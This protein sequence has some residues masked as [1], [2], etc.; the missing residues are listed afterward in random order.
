MTKK[1]LNEHF[2]N[3]ID[4]LEELFSRLSSIELSLDA[5]ELD[6]ICYRVE[7]LEQYISKKNEL[8]LFG[9]LLAESLVS[10]RKISTFKLFE[11]ILF[12]ERTINIIELPAP[13]NGNQYRSGFEHAEFVTKIPLH[14]IVKKYP[15][16][17]FEIYGIHKKTNAD[18]TLKLGDYCIRFHNQSLEDVINEEIK[19][20][21]SKNN[22]K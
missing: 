15:Q 20:G 10:G 6:H 8:S 11:P 22:T 9:D 13:K 12:R 7:S 17:A 1:L 16:Y 14:E 19:Y 18:I 4:F 5:Y 3:P 2:G 21:R